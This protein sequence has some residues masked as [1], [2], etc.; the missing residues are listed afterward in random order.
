MKDG[1]SIFAKILLVMDNDDLTSYCIMIMLIDSNC[2]ERC[3][4]ISLVYRF[5]GSPLSCNFQKTI[6]GFYPAD[7]DH[8]L[9]KKKDI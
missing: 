1:K 8:D 2:H 6:T 7:G 4:T 9:C 3:K 5:E